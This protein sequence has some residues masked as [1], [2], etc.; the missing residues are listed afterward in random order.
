MVRMWKYAHNLAPQRHLSLCFQA[1]PLHYLSSFRSFSLSWQIGRMV[2]R[3]PAL[4]TYSL[5]SGQGLP[6]KLRWLR[7]DLGLSAAQ[8]ATA[9]RALPALLTYSVSANLAP[10]KAFYAREMGAGR[11]ELAAAVAVQPSLLSYSLETRLRPRCRALRAG[12]VTPCF[13]DHALAVA[14]YTDEKFGRWL[15]R[16]RAAQARREDSLIAASADT[17]ETGAVAAVADAAETVAAATVDGAEAVRNAADDTTE[18]AVAAAADS[19]VAAGDGAVGAAAIAAIGPAAADA[20]VQP[21]TRRKSCS[22]WRPDAPVAV[23]AADS[24]GQG[25]AVSGSSNPKCGEKKKRR[26]KGGLPA[27]A[28]AG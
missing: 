26:R 4:L 18:T 15:V 11:R 28:K 24:V 14:K 12:G 1:Y 13:G 6:L 23:A 7:R 10:K 16:Q 17:D 9:V 22:E 2:A 25:V 27:A 21:K 19:V 5:S 3:A 8:A 20:V